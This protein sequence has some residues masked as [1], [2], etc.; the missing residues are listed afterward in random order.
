MTNKNLN[1]VLRMFPN[2]LWPLKFY[3]MK[4]AFKSVGVNFH[5]SVDS[6]FDNY[7]NIEVGDNVRIQRFFY[8]SNDKLFKIGNRSTI[9]PNSKVIGGDHIY[10]DPHENIRLTHKLG[11]NNEIII[12]DD[13]WIGHGCFILKNAHISEGCIVGANS[14]VNKVLQPY[15][16]YAGN[17]LRLIKPRFKTYEDLLTYL[18]FMKKEYNFDSKYSIEELSK[19]YQQ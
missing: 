6:H 14:L 4:K 3:I 19:I 5:F 7:A 8:C 15:S 18:D 10:N 11:I 16:V 13:C 17:P 9:G 1:R 2:F 12:E